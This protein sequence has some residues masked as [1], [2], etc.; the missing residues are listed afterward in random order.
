MLSRGEG[1][2]AGDGEVRDVPRGTFLAYAGIRCRESL[3]RL[4]RWC[5]WRAGLIRLTTGNRDQV[6]RML[7]DVLELALANR[8]GSVVTADP[9]RQQAESP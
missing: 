5:L 8:A 3:S 1:E 2:D 4:C 7:A 9:S 6:R